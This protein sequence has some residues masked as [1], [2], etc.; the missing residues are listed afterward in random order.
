MTDGSEKVPGA[1]ATKVRVRA[2]SRDSVTLLPTL[3]HARI[4]ARQGDVD[5]ARR[6]LRAML[7]EH[8]EDADAR[9]L[10]GRD[11]S[12]GVALEELLAAPVPGDPGALRRGAVVVRLSEWLERI[13][14]GKE[15]ERAR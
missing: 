9:A 15:R 2:P 4:R 12:R 3:T 1:A 13:Q 6:I 5:G 10:L 7:A 11:G 8:P 14:K